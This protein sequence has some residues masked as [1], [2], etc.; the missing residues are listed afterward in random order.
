M[1]LQKKLAY[2]VEDGKYLPKNLI[3]CY[4]ILD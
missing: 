1:Y 3:S 2:E 4:S